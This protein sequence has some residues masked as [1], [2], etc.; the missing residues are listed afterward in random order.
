MPTAGR[1]LVWLN[2]LIIN[3]LY[4]IE[5]GTSSITNVSSSAEA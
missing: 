3:S 5:S 2:D 4:R 1:F